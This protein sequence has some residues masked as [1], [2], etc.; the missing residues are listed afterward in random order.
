MKSRPSPQFTERAEPA[1]PSK[2]LPATAE[3]ILAAVTATSA[4]LAV[5]TAESASLAEETPRFLSC[6]ESVTISIVE[7][8]TFTS[9]LEEPSLP[10]PAPAT[11]ADIF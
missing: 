8:S 10:R 3:E 4:I 7:S 5:D 2:P 1:P 6:R 9:K 11:P